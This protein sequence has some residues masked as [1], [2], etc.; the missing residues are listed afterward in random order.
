MSIMLSFVLFFFQDRAS[1]CSTDHS[2]THYI[3]DAD[4][5]LTKVCLPC[6][7]NDGIEV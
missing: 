6:L 2:G 7:L 1:L 3:N 5:K 4:L